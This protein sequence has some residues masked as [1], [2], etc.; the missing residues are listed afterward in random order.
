MPRVSRWFGWLMAVV[1]ATTIV[2]FGLIAWAN[3]AT[4]KTQIRVLPMGPWAVAISCE[5]GEKAWVDEKSTALLQQADTK[6]K[7][8]HDARLVVTCKGH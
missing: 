6:N 4:P 1:L 5:S 2:L 7:E 8:V 3:A